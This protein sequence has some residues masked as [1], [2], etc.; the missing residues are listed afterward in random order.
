MRFGKNRQGNAS[1]KRVCKHEQSLT[2]EVLPLTPVCFSVVCCF[3]GVSTTCIK[4]VQ[5][6]QR[7]AL[8]LKPIEAG[9]R[10]YS[11]GMASK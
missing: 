2:C 7:A 6:K 5:E 8:H 4:G 11:G 10:L 9:S 1:K 3:F